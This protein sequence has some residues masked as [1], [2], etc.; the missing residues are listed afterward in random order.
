MSVEYACEDCHHPLEPVDGGPPTHCW[1]CGAHHVRASAAAIGV[2]AS[3]S[4]VV[5]EAI[6]LPDIGLYIPAV[7]TFGPKSADGQLIEAVLPAWSE[8]ARLL[9]RDPNALYEIDWRK[10]EEIIAGAYATDG[11]SVTLTPRSRDRGRDIIAEKH[12][13]MSVRI[14]DS[15]KAYGPGRR[16]TA[17]EVR[18]LYGV[19]DLD[20]AH[21]GVLSTTSS[22]APE[23]PKDPLLAKVI[24]HRIEL[25][26]GATLIQRLRRL[27]K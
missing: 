4:H 9:E 22:F 18:A 6:V 26:D 12:G 13:Y 10:M 23:I 5:G 27:A 1:N 21:K 25:I 19:V 20:N 16:V 14:I 15:V 2:T 3:A 7:L 8:I 24:P 17:E 11:Y